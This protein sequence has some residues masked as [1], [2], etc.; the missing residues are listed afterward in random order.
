VTGYGLNRNYFIGLKMVWT[1]DLAYYDVVS[2]MP[3][4]KVSKR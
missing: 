1:N 2:L 3:A 4:K